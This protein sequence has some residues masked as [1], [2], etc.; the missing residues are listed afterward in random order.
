MSRILFNPP[1]PLAG[2]TITA[3][4]FRCNPA[5]DEPPRMQTYIVPAAG[6]VSV[7]TLLRTI[8]ERIDPTLAF[9][10]QQCNAGICNV[11]RQWQNGAPFFQRSE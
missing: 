4:V 1:A 5:L 3:E 10:N 6:P 7:L 9:R 2:Q 8:Q 11:C